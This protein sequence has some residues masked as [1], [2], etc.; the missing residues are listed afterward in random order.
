MP[1]WTKS[2]Q[3]TFEYYLVDPGTWKD[4]KKIDVVTSSSVSRDASAETR[5]SATFSVTDMIE[6]CYIR[7]Y[8]VTIQNG[9]K[10]RHA[11]GTHMVQTPSSK[12]N[13]KTSTITL[14]GYTSLLE[15]KENRPPI[16]YFVPKD[17]NVMEQAYLI[18]RDRVRAPVIK[19]Q[20]L[21]TTSYDFVA[22][23]NDTWLT[24]LSD[25]VANQVYAD[26]DAT[27]GT[28]ITNYILDVD[29]MGHIMFAPYQDQSLM[30]PI[31]TYTDDNSSI[32][33]PEINMEHDLYGIP[34]V[35]EVVYSGATSFT[36]SNAKR[37]YHYVRVEN[38]DPGSPISIE[39]RGREIVYRD[40]NPSFGGLP[41]DTMINEYAVQ[42]MKAVGKLQCSIT[43]THGYCPVR[44]GDCVRLNYSKAGL[45][46]IKAKVISQNIKCV[47]GCPVTEKAVYSIDLFNHKYLKIITADGEST[48]GVVQ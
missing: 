4:L 20:C 18:A 13:G 35:V 15:L 8:L 41:T 21:S 29:E 9:V 31:W 12:F 6:E 17:S 11:L 42:L 26:T 10:E 28:R 23:T 3:H 32:L 7:T 1:N 40:L 37:E 43:Y 47:P 27:N 5:G 22:D 45:N 38:H 24:Y 39:S 2:M 16:G 34:N 25:L 19:T 33:Y 36:N 48:G 14:D 46:N 44:L 30:Q